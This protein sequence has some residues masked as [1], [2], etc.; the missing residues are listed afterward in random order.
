MKGV[1]HFKK[2]GTIY[3]GKHTHK[4]KSGKLMS[5]KTHTSKSVF[6]F[7]MKDLSKKAKMKAKNYK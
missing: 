4:D 3:R 1:S 6:L 5:G 7:H 2:D